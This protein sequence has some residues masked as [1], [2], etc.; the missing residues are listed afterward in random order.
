MKGRKSYLANYPTNSLFVVLEQSQ[1]ELLDLETKNMNA[2]NILLKHR[3]QQVRLTM[4]IAK[5]SII[6][7]Y[8]KDTSLRECAKLLINSV[9]I[10]ESVYQE[11]FTLKLLETNEMISVELLKKAIDKLGIDQL[12]MII[13]MKENTIYE[14]F[15]TECYH[16]MIFDVEEEVLGELRE[17][18]K[19]DNNR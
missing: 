2:S 10:K 14:Q 15:A 1:I 7:R 12:M 3:I 6:E 9:G 4:A 19:L 13:R 5:N 8:L 16:N 17:K 18:I 11:L